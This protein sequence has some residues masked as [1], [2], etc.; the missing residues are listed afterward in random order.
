[1]ICWA[2]LIQA[3]LTSCLAARPLAVWRAEIVKW[4]VLFDSPPQLCLLVWAQV[5]VGHLLANL[6]F[7]LEALLS[8]PR[9]DSS[10]LG[11]KWGRNIS[12]RRETKHQRDAQPE[13]A[14]EAAKSWPGQGGGQQSAQQVDKNKAQ[15]RRLWLSCLRW[16]C[17]RPRCPASLLGPGPSPGAGSDEDRERGAA[18]FD[19][20]SHPRAPIWRRLML[21]FGPPA[22][23]IVVL[24]IITD[25]GCRRQKVHFLLVAAHSSGHKQRANTL[26]E[27]R[28][29][30]GNRCRLALL[31]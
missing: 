12:R 24:V 10:G 27:R 4:L 29:E 3:N 18:R 6:H 11:E 31:T 25:E 23:I 16:Y 15:G 20:H 19:P 21:L 22:P 13:G 28:E 14:K 7:A 26:E 1:M 30:A 9:L 17:R 5:E 2:R 8:S